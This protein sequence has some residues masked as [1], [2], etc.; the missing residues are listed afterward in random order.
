M[1][2]KNLILVLGV[3]ILFLVSCTAEKSSVTKVTEPSAPQ[4]AVTPAPKT[5]TTAAAQTS[6]VIPSP[7]QQMT[8]E[9]KALLELHK[10]IKSVRFIKDAGANPQTFYV[11]GEKFKKTVTPPSR[12]TDPSD[13]YD[14]VYVDRAAQ[15]AYAYCSNSN[16][17]KCPLEYRNESYEL[18]FQSE[19]TIL[20]LDLFERFT[21]AEKVGKENV[22]DRQTTIIQFTN[23]AGQKEKFWLD[24]FFGFVF[25]QAI[26][27]A[28]DQVIESHTFSN[29]AFD[30]LTDSDVSLPKGVQ[31][32]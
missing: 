32:K 12:Y 3:L 7:T 13:N 20:P 21:Y 8:A 16:T 15:K 29:V 1:V 25:R 9:V 26:Y 19:D 24:S 17:L 2:K 11:K 18:D 30:S 4:K 22:D 14:V 28:N 5:E 6:T 10:N 31:I 27:D 23:P